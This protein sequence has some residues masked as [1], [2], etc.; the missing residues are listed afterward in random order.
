MTSTNSTNSQDFLNELNNIAGAYTLYSG[1]AGVISAMNVF[2]TNLPQIY[3]VATGTSLANENPIA[4]LGGQ[5]SISSPSSNFTA[6]TITN[7]QSFLNYAY[8]NILGLNA[9][10]IST[11][12][13]NP[14]Y[15]DPSNPQSILYGFYQVFLLS[16]GQDV[17]QGES[18]SDQS[19]LNPTNLSGQ[20]NALFTNFLQNFN[21]SV[22]N[23]SGL[24]TG[25]YPLTID[26]QTYQVS[27]PNNYN[28]LFQS[29]LTYLSTTTF[30]QSSTLTPGNAAFEGNPLFNTAFGGSS[31]TYIQSYEQIY[32]AFEGPIQTTAQQSAFVTR[33][34][35]FYTYELHKTA[36][37]A[38]PSG[39]FDPSQD[40]ADWY[41]YTSKL[42]TN[43]KYNPS[44]ALTD[45]D[46]TVILDTVLLSLINMIGTIQSV[47]AAQANTLNFLSQWQQSYTSKL[48]QLHTFA[49]GDGTVLGT[50]TSALVQILPGGATGVAD[51]NNSWNQDGAQ[52]VRNSLNSVNQSYLS[53]LTADQNTIADNAKS[54]QSNVNQSS[55]EASQE[56]SIADSI[57][58]EMST[59]VSSIF[60]SSG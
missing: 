42:Y 36:T 6:S 11:I 1:N 53:K 15:S 57:L 29:F 46:S 44:S 17:D 3:R 12:E 41:N 55:D 8:S 47:A 18:S 16:Q 5:L 58:Q 23:N 48:N 4:L 33:L 59:I 32:E 30:L 56:A 34:S 37:T 22:I 27:S 24:S 51:S 14:I 10:Q 20:F 25:S 45:R 26:H 2:T 60:S 40:L 28:N 50:F 43:P 31:T 7:V 19:I 52:A 49:Q 35:A 13:S 39:F 21:F 9:S 38:Q 54:L